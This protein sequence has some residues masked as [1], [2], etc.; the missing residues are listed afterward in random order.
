MGSRSASQ[1]E[2]G[3][4]RYPDGSD[5]GVDLVVRVAGDQRRLGRCVADVVAAGS[6]HLRTHQTPGD[7]SGQ[8]SQELWSADPVSQADG[9]VCRLVGVGVTLGVLSAL[10]QQVQSDRTLLVGPG[11]EMERCDPELSE[12]DFAMRTAHDLEGGPPNRQ[13]PLRRLSRRRSG[14]RSRDERGRGSTATIKV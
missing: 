5:G 9:A 7:L 8:R 13:A 10:P 11:E 3:S 4:L 14:S 1:G 12:G 2:T 6:G